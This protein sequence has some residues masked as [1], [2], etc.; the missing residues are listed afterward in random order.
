MQKVVF[1]G[2]EYN[3]RGDVGIHPPQKSRPIPHKNSY[4]QFPAKILNYRPKFY[5]IIVP[6]L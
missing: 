1:F 3:N 4:Y 5:P 6:A 2:Q